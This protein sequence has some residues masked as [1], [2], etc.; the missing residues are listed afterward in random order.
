MAF[1]YEAAF[2][3][4]INKARIIEQRYNKMLEERKT[5]VE[6]MSD[7]KN[8]L[9]EKERIIE[10]LQIKLE[11]MQIASSIAPSREQLEKSKTMISDLVREIDRCITDL[12][13]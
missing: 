10:Q 1:D 7:L 3:R 12:S 9:A 13:D 4:I 5:A 8:Q 11:Y 2:T 6:A